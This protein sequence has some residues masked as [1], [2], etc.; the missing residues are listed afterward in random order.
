MESSLLADEDDVEAIQ[1]LIGRLG[2]RST[3]VDFDEQM[4]LANVRARTRLWKEAGRLV[5]FAFVDDFN[6]LWFD[7]E[8]DSALAGPF[9]SEIVQW[10]EVCARSRNA[11]VG[12][13]ASLD[14]CC[15]ADAVDR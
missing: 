10:G 14:H 5:G 3:V 4:C 1:A 11:E 9:G 13:D 8:S 2:A 7:T 6:N 12:T 15:E